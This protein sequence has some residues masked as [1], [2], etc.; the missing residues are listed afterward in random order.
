VT[1]E[2]RKQTLEKYGKGYELLAEGIKKFPREMWTFRPKEG[3]SIHEIIVH[4]TDSE[5]NSYARGRRFIAEPGSTVMGYD[6]NGWAVA[7]KYLDQNPDE[8]LELFRLLRASTYDLVKTLPD[9]VWTHTVTHTESGP[10][11]MER[12]LQIYADHITNHL[13]Q[14]QGVYDEWKQ[15]HG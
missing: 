6:E 4:I 3:W 15:Q 1:P 13:N 10:M 14:M 2:E 5:A 11:G 9:E 8:A 7:L 12:W